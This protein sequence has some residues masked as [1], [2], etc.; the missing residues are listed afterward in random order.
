MILRPLNPASLTHKN[1]QRHKII[2]YWHA[3]RRT[4][5]TIDWFEDFL[6]EYPV[7]VICGCCLKMHIYFS[8]FCALNVQNDYIIFNFSER[9]YRV[10]ESL[11]RLTVR[12]HRPKQDSFS[13]ELG[14]TV[15]G[16]GLMSFHKMSPST[17]HNYLQHNHW[18]YNCSLVPQFL[19]RNTHTQ[20]HQKHQS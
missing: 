2:H 9:G 16:L 15:Y 13:F 12:L 11:S 1:P 4:K 6:V 5:R 17:H 7:C 10:L 8:L 20:R 3:S 18:L 14:L 19:P